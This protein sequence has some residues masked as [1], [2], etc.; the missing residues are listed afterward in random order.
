[1]HKPRCIVLHSYIFRPL[2]QMAVAVCWVALSLAK[3]FE[4]SLAYREKMVDRADLQ[5]QLSACGFQ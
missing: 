5:A 1:M 3:A 4:H 2:L